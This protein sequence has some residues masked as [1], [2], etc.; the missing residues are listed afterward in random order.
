MKG[1]L[2]HLA[3]ISATAAAGTLH[4]AFAKVGDQPISCF[5]VPGRLM[6]LLSDPAAVKEVMSHHETWWLAPSAADSWKS[7]FPDMLTG[8][9]GGKWSLHRRVLQKVRLEALLPLPVRIAITR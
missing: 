7:A 9:E 6:I 3:F 8:I 1:R 2:G 5:K 4:E